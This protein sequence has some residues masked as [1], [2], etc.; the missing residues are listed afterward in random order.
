M[1]WTKALRPAWT[2]QWV[3]DTLVFAWDVVLV[4][5]ACPLGPLPLTVWL[6]SHT[7][8]Y[9]L[10]P[11]SRLSVNRSFYFSGLC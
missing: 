6:F 7:H 8:M 1:T 10:P 9:L 4:C 5:G 3:L 2:A 11:P